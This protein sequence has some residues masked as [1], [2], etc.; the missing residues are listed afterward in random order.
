MR[1]HGVHEVRMGAR[2]T[3][4]HTVGAVPSRARDGSPDHGLPELRQ[5]AFRFRSI[6][7]LCANL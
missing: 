3:G 7:S 6:G 1:L 5:P 2:P 4:G